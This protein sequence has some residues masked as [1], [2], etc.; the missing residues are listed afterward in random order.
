[1]GDLEKVSTRNRFSYNSTV[2]KHDIDNLYGDFNN[3]F[4]VCKLVK[5]TSIIIVKTQ[6]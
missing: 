6:K 5:W 4:K 2:V 3:A 1:M